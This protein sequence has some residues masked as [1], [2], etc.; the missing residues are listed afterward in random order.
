MNATVGIGQVAASY[1]SGYVADNS[2]YLV[3][4]VFFI[5]CMAGIGNLLFVFHAFDII[6]IIEIRINMNFALI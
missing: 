3:L 1:I 6:Q 2:G 4:E 5:S